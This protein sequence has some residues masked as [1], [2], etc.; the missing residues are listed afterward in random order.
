MSEQKYYLAMTAQEKY[1]DITKPILFLGPWCML[2]DR[3]SHWEVQNA[4]EMQSPFSAASDAENAYDYVEEVYESV[5][6][7][8]AAKLNVLNGKSYS[9][10]YWRIVLGGWLQNYISV[11]YD[12]YAH[13][14]KALDEYPDLTTTVIS[15]QSF[16]TSSSTFDLI[17]KVSEDFFNHQI[18]SKIL[19]FCG[20]NFPTVKIEQQHDGSYNKPLKKSWKHKVV[21]ILSRP[22]L[23]TIS[24]VRPLQVVFRHTYLP[25]FSELQLWK[26]FSGKILLMRDEERWAPA[27]EYNSNLRDQIKEISFGDDEFLKC[28]SEMLF[29]DMPKCFVEDF[30]TT[31]AMGKAKYPDAPKVIFSA[32]AWYYDEIFKFWAADCAEKGTVLLGTPHGGNYGNLFKEVSINHEMAIVDNYYSW[33]WDME[34]CAAEVIPMPATKLMNL[35]VMGANSEKTGIL[36]VATSSTRYLMSFPNLP[37]SFREYLS[38]QKRFLEALVGRGLLPEVLFRAHYQDNGWG[39]VSRLKEAEPTLSVDSW[40]TPFR[41]RLAQCRLYV[42]DHL[43]TTFTEALASNKPTILFW[44]T[45]VNKLRPEAE[46]YF[47]LLRSAGVLFDDPDAAAEAVSYAYANVELWWHDSG[48]QQAVS[49]F[50]NQFAHTS[51]NAI[52]LWADEL[53]RVVD[54]NEK[55]AH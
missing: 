6:P 39:I 29:A 47:D 53:H 27:S 21:N 13:I 50:C 38:W 15:E 31:C 11:V 28:L 18:Y 16:V 26:S 32:N 34:G 55:L 51:P 30:Q 41:K 49:K 22:Y 19:L 35:K 3:R 52:Q 24:K 42:C 8:L 12:R 54:G 43:S 33:G 14:R 48:R 5:L 46:P 25:V 4:R 9:L 37:K 36:W 1:W 17:C 45:D 20:K 10:R 7:L 23:S 40:S 2:Y 44:D